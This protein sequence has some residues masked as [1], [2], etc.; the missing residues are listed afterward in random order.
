M[1]AGWRCRGRRGTVVNAG[2]ISAI[3][4][5]VTLADAILLSAGGSVR[6]LAGGTIYGSTEGL[7]I[8]DGAGRRV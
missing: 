5:G 4:T 1:T 7:V 2:M 6:N 3:S 8:N